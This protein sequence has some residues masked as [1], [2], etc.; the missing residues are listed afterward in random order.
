MSD[1]LQKMPPDVAK[2]LY[3][4][5]RQG[6]VSDATLQ[7]HGYRLDQFVEW[8]ERQGIES[9]SEIDGVALHEYRVSR[10]DEDGIK[11]VTLQGQ[12]STLRQ[13]LRVC[14]SVDAVADELAENILLPTVSK[15][16]QSSDELL[17]ADR[18]KVALEYLDEYQY[19][20]RQ[21]VELLLFWR[22]SRRRGGLR[23]RDVEDFD[24]NEPALEVRH[25]PDS[26]TQLKNGEWSERDISIADRVAEVLEDYLA[27]CRI[28]IED[29]FGREPLL[30]TAQG[31]PALSTLKRDMYQ[32]TRPCEYGCEC[33]HER[34][35]AECEALES[36]MASKCPSSRS[37]HAI[38]TG[39][40]TAYL[41]EGTPKP[42][43]ADRV[44]MSEDT[45]ELHYDK[46]SN[47]ER[48]YRRRDYVPEEV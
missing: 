19:A 23:A 36:G 13:F 40:V 24:Q 30:T 4:E 20:S 45:M 46:A 42:V 6:E 28:E 16:A 27:D 29:E 2:D 5:H 8:C 44:D 9:M 26:D 3:I 31:R 18:A 47:R 35:T 38:R 15:G 48:M 34:D 12:L 43:L 22:T 41:D 1:D 7:S 33:P 17:E 37:P 10:R 25:R 39:S 21:H 11:P 32:V 14:A